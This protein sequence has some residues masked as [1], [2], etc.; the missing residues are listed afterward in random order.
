MYTHMYI[1]Y[2]HFLLTSIHFPGEPTRLRFLWL[3]LLVYAHAR[4]NIKHLIGNT[5]KR[6]I[7]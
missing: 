1:R 7:E 5:N 3:N 6:Q 2:I 4:E